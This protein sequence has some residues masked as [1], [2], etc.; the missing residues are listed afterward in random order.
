MATNSST[1]KKSVLDT[2]NTIKSNELIDILNANLDAIEKDPSL[3][4]E[5]P[6]MLIWG[7]PGCGKSSIVRSVCEQRGI[8]FKDVRLAQMEPCDIKGLP[9]PNKEEKVMEWY[10][11]GSWPRNPNG[12]GIIFLDEITASDRSIQVAA[13]ELVLDRRLGELYSVPPGYMIVA[14]GNKT[15][16]KAVAY[17]MSSALANRFLHVELKE[18]SEAWCNWARGNNI[19]PS[20]IGFITYRPAMLFKM[21]NENLERGWPSPRSWAR[22]SQL[23]HL[24]KNEKESTL[25][26]LVYGLVGNGA[27]AEFMNFYKINESFDN[28]LDTMLNPNSKIVIPQE[29]DRKYALCSAMVYLMWRGADAKEEKMRLNGFY[30]ICIELSSDFASMALLAALQGKD[31]AETKYRCNALLTHPLFKEWKEKHGS[32]LQKRFDISKIFK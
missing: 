32:A 17:T 29:A 15:D 31:K 22:V 3:T 5:L 12:E 9:V 14:A 8:E 25:R 26:K 16:D 19:H 1:T 23:C 20:V 7:S 18:D 28:I 2:H 6:P 11:N 30:R 27:G 10:I 21:E 13:Y 24:F 4:S